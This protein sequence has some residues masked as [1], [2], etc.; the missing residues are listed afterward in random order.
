MINSDSYS[1]RFETSII[2]IL[3][4]AVQIFRDTDLTELANKWVK[5]LDNYKMKTKFRQLSYQ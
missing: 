3:E 1:L 2:K 4:R 5:I